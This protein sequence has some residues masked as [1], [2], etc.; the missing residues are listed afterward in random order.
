MLDLGRWSL[1]RVVV[2]SVLWVAF[3]VVMPV[4]VVYLVMR[5]QASSTGSGSGAIGAV[6]VGFSGLDVFAVVLGPPIVLTLAWLYR[7]G[8]HRRA[9]KR[10]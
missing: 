1:G 6:S 2:V 4:A 7:R 8:K 5:Y 10:M 3:V 9:A